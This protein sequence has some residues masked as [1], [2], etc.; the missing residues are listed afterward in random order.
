[1]SIVRP[2]ARQKII[3]KNNAYE[4]SAQV[5][6]KALSC[7]HSKQYDTTAVKIKPA[8]PIQARR[9]RCSSVNHR[10]QRSVIVP[11]NVGMREGSSDNQLTGGSVIIGK[12]SSSQRSAITGTEASCC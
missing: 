1:M 6:L 11:V 9:G 2:A 8:T 7:L 5:P 10:S 12:V 3:L 4:S